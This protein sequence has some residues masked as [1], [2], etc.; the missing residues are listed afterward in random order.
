MSIVTSIN[1]LLCIALVSVA[2]ACGAPQEGDPDF[3]PPSPGP[4]G[5]AAATPAA[6]RLVLASPSLPTGASSAE[7]GVKITAVVTDAANNALAEQEVAFSA[8][9]GV[10][11]VGNSKTDANGAATVT[12]TTGGDPTPRTISIGAKA[13]KGGASTTT[14]IPVSDAAA[15]DSRIATLNLVSDR[16][17]LA[18]TD[19]TT[20]KAINLQ[21]IAVDS[22]GRLLPDVTVSF[23]IPTRNAALAITNA[24]TNTDG[25]ALAKLTTGGDATPRTISVQVS[26]AQV[27]ATK[28]IQVTGTSN[29]SDQVA[30]LQLTKNK[31]TLRT[32]DDDFTKGVQITATATNAAGQVQQGTP[33][34]FSITSGGGAI[35]TTQGT[36]DAAGRAIALLSTG[37]NTAAR[38]IVVTA[39]AGSR[40]ATITVPV[41]AQS[42]PVENIRLSTDRPF[43]GTADATAARALTIT[44]TLTNAAGQ[45]VPE[46]KVEFSILSGG[47]AIQPV[48]S[49]IS[50]AQGEATARLTTGGDNAARTIRVQAAIAGKTQTVDVPVRAEAS[51]VDSIGSVTLTKNRD[52]L[53]TTD[54][55]LEQAVL[56]TATV[57]DSGGRTLA[58]APVDFTLTT[59]NGALTVDSTTTDSTGR[60][61]A[62]L[63]TGGNQTPRTITAR[64]AAGS[65]TA[66]VDI[67]VT[68]PGNAN[69]AVVRIAAS[70][71]RSALS[72]TD[73]TLEEAVTISAQMLDGG[74]VAVTGAR[75]S[76]SITTGGGALTVNNGGL[77][78]DQGVAT[79]RLTNG[80]DS[81]A[82]TIT[83][84]IISG[85]ASTTVN[86]G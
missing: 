21:A 34:A 44:A 28:T 46:G 19:A 49:G 75:A 69:N 29:P 77:T 47:G 16:E 37:G 70:T 62:R 79:A 10:L 22:Q 25:V 23:T 7:T 6:V 24:T 61:Q 59:G 39:T 18:T 74:G 52:S 58:N 82:R 38:N 2:A 60:A 73:D 65:K 41:A 83:V 56:L 48:N 55:Q 31:E 43:L 42:T 13:T 5:P 4:T 27:S 32:T 30:S 12:L 57:L 15:A 36:T 26:A 54:A 17:A 53:N 8:D 14:T 51:V 86:V 63:T 20:D 11:I 84:S 1:R 85:S 71:S 45:V 81:S 72:P 67:P 80:G 64:V 9:T 35:Q 78:D 50:D 76:F 40:S 33:V 66:T 68:S 3:V